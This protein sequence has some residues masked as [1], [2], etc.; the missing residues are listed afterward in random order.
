MKVMSEKRIFQKNINSVYV[1]ANKEYVGDLG[2][3]SKDIVGKTDLDFH[4]KELAERYRSDDKRIMELGKVEVLEEQ[5]D[6]QGKEALVHMIKIPV[7]GKEGKVNGIIGGVL[8]CVRGKEGAG[9]SGE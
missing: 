9:Y 2:I 6:V 1:W 8:G 3:E 7:R 5:Y 4:S